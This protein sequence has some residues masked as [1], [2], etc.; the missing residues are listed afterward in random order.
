MYALGYGIPYTEW[1]QFLTS[2]AVHVSTIKPGTP[3]G[4]IIPPEIVH[5]QRGGR[6]IVAASDNWDHNERTVDG[7]R[8]THVM[9]SILVSP[10]TEEHLSFPTGVIKTAKLFLIFLYKTWLKYLKCFL[11]VQQLQQS[12]QV[13]LKASMR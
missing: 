1:R 3:S 8:T 10:Q 12:K 2:A 4:G 13:L 6:L 9:T 11:V 5:R 7:K